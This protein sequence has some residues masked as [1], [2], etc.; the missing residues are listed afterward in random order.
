MTT[1]RIATLRA[2]LRDDTTFV[3]TPRPRLSWTVQ[4]DENAWEQASAELRAGEESVTLDGRDSV[5]VAW[6][7]AELAAGEVRDV[8]VRVRSAGGTWT[9]W[10]APLAVTAG[11][12]AEGEWI[13]QPIGLADAAREAQPALVRTTFTIGKPVRQATLLWT[14]LG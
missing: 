7:F 3:A 8:S 5:L 11:F 4:T 14:A 1:A 13:A 10:S 6:P 9:D 12:L 2:E